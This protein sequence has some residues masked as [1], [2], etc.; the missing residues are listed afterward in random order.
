MT[1]P[2][3]RRTDKLKRREA[4]IA[5]IVEDVQ[6]EIEDVLNSAPDS[7]TDDDRES[8]KDEVL[9]H[10]RLVTDAL[11]LNELENEGARWS[12]VR[13]ANTTAEHL[14]NVRLAGKRT[15]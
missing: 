8:I 11:S 6:H 12:H 15:G 7:L 3:N 10:S 13:S 5:E 2:A 14:V 9:Q 4:L 1:T